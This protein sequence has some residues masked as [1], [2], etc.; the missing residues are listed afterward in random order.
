MSNVQTNPQ[1]EYR[2]PSIAEIYSNDSISVI[3]RD[4]QLQRLL[5][6]PPK[7]E[8]LEKHPYATKKVV[9]NG[10]VI[11]EPADYLPVQRVEWLLT[12]IFLK[13]RF[14]IKD[15]KLIANSVVVVG[16]LHYFDYVSSDWSW[17]D[18]V[19]ACPL[20]TDKGHGATDFNAIKSAAV[21]MGAPAAESFALKDAAEKIGKIFGK[22]LNRRDSISYSSIEKRY[23]NIL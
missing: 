6:E 9:L 15:V 11:E 2:L 22:D 8:W 10:R 3:R 5:N 16:R 1:Q 23:E 12:N 21:Q 18:G 13:W 20:Q 14:E 4:A 19:G 17:Q 7:P